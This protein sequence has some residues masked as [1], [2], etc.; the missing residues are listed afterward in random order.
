[1]AHSSLIL[2]SLNISVS[3][4]ATIVRITCSMARVDSYTALHW[5]MAAGR[6]F[7]LVPNGALADDGPNKNVSGGERHDARFA[8]DSR[9]FVAADR[10][11][12]L[13]GGGISEPVGSRGGR[14][15]ARRPYR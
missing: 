7:T 6:R 3:C 2:K 11:R 15:S 8:V 10:R 5:R 13:I 14:V 1:M 9:K 4:W 12:A